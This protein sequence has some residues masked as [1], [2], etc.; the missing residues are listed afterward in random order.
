MDGAGS[1]RLS[2][3]GR[4]V[5]RSFEVRLVVL[6]PGSERSFDEAV[7]HDALIVVER[8]DLELGCAGGSRLRIRCGDMLSLSGLGVGRLRQCGDEPA[9]LVAVSR[10]RF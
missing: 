6:P 9:V 10:R 3:L 2:F 1:D 5:P 4:P 7:W 8:G